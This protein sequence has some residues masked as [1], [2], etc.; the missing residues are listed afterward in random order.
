ML[1]KDIEVE[2]GY[3][4]LLYP[5]TLQEVLYALSSRM[6]DSNIASQN[7]DDKIS[8]LLLWVADVATAQQD[9]LTSLQ[10]QVEAIRQFIGM[11]DPGLPA[12]LTLADVQSPDLLIGVL[13]AKRLQTLALAQAGP[14][15]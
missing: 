3:P 8:A 12:Q 15:E 11:P 14:A 7:A 2:A 1:A 9:Q 10:T 4:V 6:L 5:G 13:Q